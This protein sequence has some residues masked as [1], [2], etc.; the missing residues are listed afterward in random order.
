MNALLSLEPRVASDVIEE[1]DVEFAEH[2]I[3]LHDGPYAVPDLCVTGSSTTWGC[4]Y[5]TQACHCA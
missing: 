3:D 2:Q 1:P 4:L 5:L